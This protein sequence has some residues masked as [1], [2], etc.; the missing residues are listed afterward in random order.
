MK[1]GL[2]LVVCCLSC[3]GLFGQE[4]WQ[5]VVERQG[6]IKVPWGVSGLSMVDSN[7]FC[8][9]NGKLLMGVP[10]SLR[11]T[12]RRI[13]KNPMHEAFISS[14]EPDTILR[15]L[16]EDMTFVVRNPYDSLYYYTV[17][18]RGV[19]RLYVHQSDKGLWRD[20]KVT[21][22][23]W[24]AEI[25]HPAFSPNGQFM[26]FSA[27][28]AGALGGYDL[29]CSSW[30]GKNWTKPVNLGSKVN[31]QGNEIHPVFYGDKLLFVSNGYTAIDET[32]SIY[33]SDFP[34]SFNPDQIIFH[35]YYVQ[36]LP[37]PLNS[38]A[39][40]WELA[41]S[42]QGDC[43]YW[44]STRTGKEEVFRFSGRLDG[45]AYLGRVVDVDGH[46]VAGATVTALRQGRIVYTS[47]T[48]TDGYYCL[49]VQPGGGYS[50][51]ARASGFFT[52]KAELP[53]INREPKFLIAEL[54]SNI[55]MRTLPIGEPFT[56]EGVFGNDANVDLT[57]AGHRYVGIVVQ[58]MIDNPDL[59]AEFS[60]NSASKGEKQFNT[61]LSEQRLSV[62]QEYVQ[63]LLPSN[64]KITYRNGNKSALGGSVKKGNNALTVI[65][66][67]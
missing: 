15:Q 22:K 16:P 34:E 61:M 17:E 65:F 38:D 43:G 23:E 42:P 66:L 8:Y 6:S 62:L 30:D 10:S 51:E 56:L 26:V 1:R 18:E 45:T 52:H 20:R 12:D 40:D 28:A 32:Y 14:F 53:T 3:L 46:P 39:D 49:F 13:F 58:F 9:S 27:M 24:R 50:M 55:T 11:V 63:S 35:D 37:E 60:I 48:G 2:V 4:N 47:R 25:C 19:S 54:S 21:P 41:L 67:R 44:V 33:S 29:W 64:G 36:R 5:F 7:L 31:T 59:K 57:E